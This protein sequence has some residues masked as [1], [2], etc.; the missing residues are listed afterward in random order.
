MSSI[1]ISM[2]TFDWYPAD[3]RVRRLAEAAAGAGY[4]VDVVCIRQPEE[5]RFEI[6]NGVRIYRVPM[7]RSF[8]NSLSKTILGWCWFLILAGATITRLHMKKAY[9][10]IHVHNM[11]DFLVLSALLPRLF[12]AKVILDVQDV[13]PELMATK[14]RGRKRALL[15][16]LACWQERL[17]TTFA[18]HVV[19]VG[20]PFEELLLKRG[21][22]RRK[23]SV[24]LNSVDPRLFPASYRERTE[25]ALT[26]KE[27][28]FILMYHGTIAER[29]GVET[30]IRALAL[31][32]QTAPNLRLDIQGQGR[33]GYVPFLKQ[34]AEDLGVGEHVVFT[35]WGP[36]ER[37]VDFVAHGD[38]G[39]IP[40][41][42][43]E[44]MELIL[45]TKAYEFAWMHRPMIASDTS[46]I[47]SMFRPESIILCD[48]SQPEAFARAIIELYQHPEKRAE[49]VENAA[50]DYKPFQWEPMANYYIQLLGIISGKP[51][52]GDGLQD[53]VDVRSSESEQRH[54]VASGESFGSLQ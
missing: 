11:P 24:I 7:D 6:C 23:L 17:S 15:R 4:A 48:A 12:G 22:P 50:R 21:V 20:W 25:A 52:E 31:A 38:V 19:T 44:F 41:N 34:L 37:V 33:G 30:A 47:R 18:D 16:K 40:Y 32:R 26:G 28:P 53:L 35:E 36:F 54:F 45:P 10:V 13:S 9:D 2:I 51:S 46:A 49:M 5:A 29:N 1:H 8:S 39:L 42:N 27:T 3:P 43:D 14:A